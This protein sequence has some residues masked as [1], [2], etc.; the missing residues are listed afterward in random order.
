LKLKAAIY[1]RVSM[2]DQEPENQL[3]RLGRNL[4]HPITLLNSESRPHSGSGYNAGRKQNACPSTFE[5][6]GRGAPELLAPH[7]LNARSRIS[8]VPAIVAGCGRILARARHGC[9]RV[10]AAVWDENHIACIE[11]D[12]DPRA[13]NAGQL[14]ASAC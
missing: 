13:V 7:L 12:E 10:A 3:D 2:V 4:K 14:R 6:G 8:G 1:A 5:A 9:G 11:A